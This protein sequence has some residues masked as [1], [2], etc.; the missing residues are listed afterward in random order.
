M[1]YWILCYAQ[2]HKQRTL[3]NR[4]ANLVFSVNQIEDS[5]AMTRTRHVLYFIQVLGLMVASCG[6][7]DPNVCPNVTN[8]LVEVSVLFHIT[9]HGT[10]PGRAQCTVYA[11]AKL[12]TCTYEGK[13]FYYFTNYASSMSACGGIAYNCFGQEMINQGEDFQKW[14][15]FLNDAEDVQLLWEKDP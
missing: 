4:S 9:T 2:P 7:D 3:R 15:E 14:S 13:P 1:R 6:K 12:Y 11:G 8:H 10:V 5:G